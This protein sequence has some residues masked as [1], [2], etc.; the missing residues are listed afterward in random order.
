MTPRRADGEFHRALKAG[1]SSNPRSTGWNLAHGR[2]LGPRLGEGLGPLGGLD[3]DAVSA[4]VPSRSGEINAARFWHDCCATLETPRRPGMP[5]RVPYGTRL[6]GRSGKPEPLS[7]AR[8]SPRHEDPRRS[9][10]RAAADAHRGHL[11]GP[12]LRGCPATGLRRTFRRGPEGAASIP[13]HAG[14]TGCH[15]SGVGSRRRGQEPGS[16]TG[17]PGVWPRRGHGVVLRTPR[18]RRPSSWVGGPAPPHSG[19]CP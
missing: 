13:D 4:L 6:R 3:L 15:Q 8:R 9:L 7:T 18:C 14:C 12:G 2:Y 1:T 16:Q 10:A 17:C 19:P 11:C 5:L